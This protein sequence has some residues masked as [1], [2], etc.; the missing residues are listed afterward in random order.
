MRSG[1]VHVLVFHRRLGRIVDKIK[2]EVA[3]GTKGKVVDGTEGGDLLLVKTSQSTIS[4]VE[5]FFLHDIVSELP[6]YLIGK[7]EIKSQG[8][9]LVDDQW[10]VQTQ[11]CFF[12]F[13]I[14]A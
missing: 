11:V 5:N 2:E 13:T 8:Q 7:R 12:Q 4:G 1:R 9:L 10:M 14:V 6:Y 3:E